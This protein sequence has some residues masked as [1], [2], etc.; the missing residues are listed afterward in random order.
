MPVFVDLE[1]P[2]TVLVVFVGVFCT[3]AHSLSLL[4]PFYYHFPF[5]RR[6][7]ENLSSLNSENPPK[8]L[9]KREEF[10]FSFVSKKKTEE[11]SFFLTPK[12]QYKDIRE[13]RRGEETRNKKYI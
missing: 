2:S 10:F 7:G 5:E 12:I 11:N 8:R 1:K 6:S 3:F 13:E 9:L 4:G